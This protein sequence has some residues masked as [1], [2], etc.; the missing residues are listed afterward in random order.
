VLGQ[1]V[2]KNMFPNG[3]DPIGRY[4]L[5]KNVPFE[6]VGVLA[7][8]GANAFGSDMDNIALVPLSTGYMRLFGKRF[9]NEIIV[10]VDN[11]QQILA[12]QNAIENTIK[13]RHGAQDFQIRNTSSLLEAVSAT[14]N[15]LTLLLGSVA[16]I[17]LLVGGI[18]VMNIMLV[19]VTERTREIGVR[20]ATGAR[21]ANILLQFNTEALVIC[22]IGGL[23]GVALGFAVGFAAQAFGMKVSFTA[24]PAL[25]AFCSSFATG[26]LF[27][28]LPARK[29]ANLD[30]VVALAS[31]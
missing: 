4:V 12:T 1:T 22:G 24:A 11:A 17:S 30:P 15:T 6:I 21:A 20:M 19:T 26:L 13:A 8:K 27:G 16:A 5:V 14:Q 31:E 25:L 10:K 29:A 7:G 18:G 3:E 28:Y 2:E 9:L 23:C